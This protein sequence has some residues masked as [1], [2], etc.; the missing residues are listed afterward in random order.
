MATMLIAG[1]GQLGS[2]YLQ[3]AVSCRVPLTIHV[4]DVNDTSLGRA[5]ERWKEARG[6]ESHHQ[7]SFQA[8]SESLPRSLDLAIIATT[9]DVRPR[10]VGE[11][12]ACSAVRF[13]VLEKLLAQSESG[14]DRLVSYVGSGARAWVNT[15]RRMMPWHQRIK[16][17]LGLDAPL[18]ATVEGGQWGLA[19]NTIHFLD[20]L[21]WWTGETLEDVYTDRLDGHWFESKRPGNFEVL[22]TLD[23]RF[24]GG[25]QAM[26]TSRDVG[27]A[28]SLE[29]SDGRLSWQVR[30]S[31][32]MACR[33]D[34]I[35][36]PGC[37]S[38]QSSLTA[39]LVESILEEGRCELPALEDSV[40]LHRVFIRRMQEH[41]ERAGHH[42][43]TVVPIT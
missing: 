8:S 34:G 39:G 35:R 32:G 28:D 7:V 5:E 4:L 1:A 2:R 43:A 18:T 19:C 15:S 17:Q 42:A 36:I 12:A 21:A 40:V 11:I 25:S 41:W 26:L 3:G 23:A 24:S 31:D 13:W 22:G 33:S 14:L 38:P 29:V 30:E 9:A 10:V 20:L 27:G 16:S 37:V 6:P